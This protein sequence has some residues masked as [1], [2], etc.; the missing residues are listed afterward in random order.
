MLINWGGGKGNALSWQLLL[1]MPRSRFMCRLLGYLG[2]PVQLD[3]LLY[4][5]EHS[6]VVQSYQPRE[7]TAGLLNADGFGIGWYHPHRQAD[8]FAYKNIQPIWSDI[9]LPGLSQYIEAG[10]VLAN[11]RSATPGQAVDLS[12]CQPFSHENLLGVHN[13]YIQDFRGTL[14]RPIRQKLDDEAYQLIGG[15]TDSEHIFA[16]LL[17]EWRFTG[18][19]NL[20]TALQKTLQTLAEMAQTYATTVS[21]NLIL[22]DG[23]QL[24][25]SR[26]ST[27]SPAPSLYWLQDTAALPDAVV[28]ASEPLFAGNWLPL[29]E[30]SILRVDKKL[31]VKMHQ[32]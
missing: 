12:N 19:I 7:M 13:G 18:A 17:S 15:S 24:V 4:Q 1:W 31:D 11:V 9:N 10:C 5:P 6:L 23:E 27:N 22:S 25:A 30:H 14:Y 26:F 3:A 32:L 8:P 20:T 21:A 16:L 28:I 2:R 29:P